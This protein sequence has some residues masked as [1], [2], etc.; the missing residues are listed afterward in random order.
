[1]KQLK[2]VLLILSLCLSLCSCTISGNNNS[3][4]TSEETAETSETFAEE[5]TV[6][7]TTVPVVTEN[8]KETT[9]T[10]KEVIKIEKPELLYF[11]SQNQTL[12]EYE[13]S[14]NIP[15]VQMSYSLAVLDDTN[16]KNY[17]ALADILDMHSKI[18][19]A[20]EEELFD[21]LKKTAQDEF[22]KD[23]DS[24]SIYTNSSTTLVRRADSLAVSLLE[25]ITDNNDKTEHKNVLSYKTY[26]YDSKTG[27]ELVLSDVIKDTAAL[28]DII[29]NLLRYSQELYNLES[30]NALSDYFNNTKEEDIKWTLENEG[31]TF[32]FDSTDGVSAKGG[33]RPV[34]IS[35][36]AHS[37][38][39][40]T[41]YML[42]PDAYIIGTGESN[43][44]YDVDDDGICEEIITKF[45]NTDSSA[46]EYSSVSTAIDSKAFEISIR[47]DK[48]NQ[49]I[50]KT[51][52]N[53]CY[54]YIFSQYLEYPGELH[55]FELT[56]DGPKYL[57]EELL[58]LHTYESQAGNTI[59][60]DIP[61][62]PEMFYLDDVSSV[63][64]DHNRTAYTISDGKP[65]IK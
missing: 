48:K 52:D 27:K 18:V 54:L 9:Q 20:S 13:T 30:P 33:S 42:Y 44:Y 49:Y 1:M 43:F 23:P 16:R 50:V 34:T 2:C 60:R 36:S 19:K 45:R 6:A 51:S 59:M 63:S 29:E 8:K 35:Y 14:K 57:G 24:F 15:L 3:S 25:E 56:T 32:Y 28:P 11:I 26:N 58:E 37:S 62:D 61:T 46:F 21:E 7:E 10:T 5:T 38:I 53:K 64:R 39:F 65:D 4:A 41:D 31:I 22:N 12:R 47:A 17:S 40:K 55:I